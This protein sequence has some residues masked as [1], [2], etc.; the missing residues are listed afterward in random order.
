MWEQHLAKHPNRQLVKFF[1]EGLSKGF[2]IGFEYTSIVLKSAQSNIASAR[3]HA[4]VV[5]E[6]LKTEIELTRVA[7]P[8]P[9][10]AIHNGHISRFGV[11]PKHHQPNKW[12]LIVDLSYPTGHSVNDGISSPLC[13]LR[14]V[15]VD[16]AVHQI[17]NLGRNCLLAKIDIKSAFRLLPVHPADRHLLLMKWNDKIYI[18]TFGLRSAPKLFNVFGRPTRMDCKS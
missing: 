6:Y 12:R 7:G 5:D 1:L 16:D 9:P 15:T 3:S 17:F 10:E 2:R 13:S 18:D 11:I 14:Y 8:F 4:N